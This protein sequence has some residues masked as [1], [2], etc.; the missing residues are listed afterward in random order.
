[1]KK[2][3]VDRV[4]GGPLDRRVALG[5]V[6]FS[7]RRSTAPTARRRSG[8]GDASFP[9][10]A[11]TLDIDFSFRSHAACASLLSSLGARVPP[12]L[13]FSDSLSR[14]LLT[15]IHQRDAPAGASVASDDRHVELSTRI[16]AWRP[17]LLRFLLPVSAW[18]AGERSKPRLWRNSARWLRLRPH[19]GHSVINLRFSRATCRESQCETVNDPGDIRALHNTNVLMPATG[20][21]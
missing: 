21:N 5:A 2:R 11:A 1:V 8:T 13:A 19:R 7:D 15:D 10:R 12:F 3:D 4:A 9:T 14:G 17:I 20:K 16:D 6:R 18:V